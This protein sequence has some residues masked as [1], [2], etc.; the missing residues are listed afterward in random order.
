MR[1]MASRVVCDPSLDLMRRHREFMRGEKF[2]NVFYA[3]TEFV[4]SI[5]PVGVI[6]EQLSILFEHGAAAGRS[7]HNV[8]TYML[9]IFDVSLRQVAR[10]VCFSGVKSQS[11]AAGLIRNFNHLLL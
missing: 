4:R 8:A 6:M 2:S 11:P 9:K 7:H 10:N 1:K 5:V 3:P